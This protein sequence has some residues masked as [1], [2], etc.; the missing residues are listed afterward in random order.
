MCR[1]DLV[2][3]F[4]PL[5][6]HR[7]R[8]VSACRSLLHLSSLYT[9]CCAMKVLKHAS[10]YQAPLRRKKTSMP[11][12]SG[13]RQGTESALA[14]LAAEFSVVAGR[15][16]W[17]RQFTALTGSRDGLL[18]ELCGLVPNF[19]EFAGHAVVCNVAL[20]STELQLPQSSKPSSRSRPDRCLHLQISTRL[21]IW[22]ARHEEVRHSPSL[23]PPRS[24]KLWV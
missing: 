11:P 22:H 4:C 5:R 8:A 16:G 15:S 9:S 18:W 19:K 12:S 1:L 7:S 13:S 21:E 10:T 17:D 24:W 3:Q 6:L 23:P 2:K 14:I 20:R